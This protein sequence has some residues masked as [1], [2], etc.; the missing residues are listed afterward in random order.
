MM[1]AAICRE[2]GSLAAVTVEDVPEPEPGPGQVR[3]RVRAASVNF[4]DV[5]IARGLYQ[6]KATPPFTPG[7]EFAGEVDAVGD[8]VVNVAVGDR[9]SGADLTGAFA[10]RIVVS[11][12]AVHPTPVGLDDV[13]AAA[14]RVAYTTAYHSLVT[15]ADA[16][17]GQTVVVLGAAGGV[18]LATVHIAD[19]LGLRVIAVASSAERVQVGIEEGADA[20]VDYSSEPLKERLKELSDGGADIVIDPVGGDIAEPAL[21]ALRWGGR[22]VTVGYASGTIPQIPLNLVLLK[23]IVVRGFEIRTLPQ[24]RPDAIEPAERALA[25]L[26]AAG[27]RPLVR[28]VYPLDEV[29]AALEHVAD[30]RAIGKVVIELSRSG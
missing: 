11:A 24:H 15:I 22:F 29:A 14:F 18:G 21:R 1:R 6:I 12:A 10:E 9:V 28:A 2:I 16:Q 19:R 26:V 4:P 5:L 20:G 30:R 17:P 7:S 23:G 27:M 13:S 8:G 25:D 3:V